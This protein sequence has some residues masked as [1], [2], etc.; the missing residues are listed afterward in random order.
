MYL[1]IMSLDIP[2]VLINCGLQKEY[3]TNIS[4]G[5]WYACAN[6]LCIAIEKKCI[7]MQICML[8]ARIIQ[9]LHLSTFVGEHHNFLFG[10][11]AGCVQNMDS[12]QLSPL[13]IYNH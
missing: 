1:T 3:T 11:R 8:A 4:I 6:F 13:K 9:N 7:K 12:F 5:Y 2:K 10:Y